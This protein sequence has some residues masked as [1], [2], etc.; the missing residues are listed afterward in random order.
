MVAAP[1]D[2][3]DT[4]PMSE[5]GD[6]AF[7]R[8]LETHRVRGFIRFMRR[9]P[10]DP[11]CAICRAPYGG[12]GGRVMG[13][14]GFA[15][16]RKNPRLCDRCFEKAPMGGVEM[17]VGI[18]FADV[19]GFTSLA[20]RE[21]PDAVAALLNRFYA[22]AVDVLCEHAIIDKL[23]GD[24]VMALYLPGVFPGEPADHMLADARALLAAS[25]YRDDEPWVRIGIG[26][27]FGSAFVGNVGSGDVKDFTAIGDVVN[28]AARLQA[29]AGSGEV[30]MSS[31]VHRRL[32]ER[33]AGVEA[34]ELDLKGKSEPEHALVSRFTPERHL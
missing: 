33:V 7:L 26:L 24:Q 3:L 4:W 13:R 5:A 10:T 27:D 30:V 6:Q 22:T 19:R 34:R 11:R 17:E 8:S 9:L 29:A 31:R 20:E 16:S 32:G 15:P 23:V 2:L 14:L 25:G 28:T 12:L 18:L 21:S 1:L